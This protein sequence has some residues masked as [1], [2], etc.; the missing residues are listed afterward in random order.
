M[1]ENKS[2]VRQKTII[3]IVVAVLIVAVGYWWQINYGNWIVYKDNINKAEFSYPKSWKVGSSPGFI[4]LASNAAHPTGP[5]LLVKVN[6]AQFFVDYLNL[7]D[8][9]TKLTLGDKTFTVAHREETV[10]GGVGQATTTATFTHLYWKDK[11]GRGYIF[12]ISP[13]QKNGLD[14]SLAQ[15][16]KSFRAM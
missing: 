10:P 11:N 1:A 7:G 13:W 6:P 2:T 14:A 4:K 9:R 3:L 12:E 5:N 16:L 8:S 15:I